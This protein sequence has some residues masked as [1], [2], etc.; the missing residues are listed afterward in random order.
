MSCLVWNFRLSSFSTFSRRRVIAIKDHESMT[1]PSVMQ[2]P[3]YVSA[4][5]MKDLKPRKEQLKGVQAGSPEL[6]FCEDQ[7]G[8]CPDGCV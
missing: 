4:Q 8:S 2:N 6:M 7:R 1:F 5:V 3:C